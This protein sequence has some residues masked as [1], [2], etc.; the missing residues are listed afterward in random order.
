M[1]KGIHPSIRFDSIQFNSIQFNSIQFN[2]IQF[3]SSFRYK[4][5]KH[6][7]G[8]KLKRK[9]GA[10]APIFTSSSCLEL[11]SSNPQKP[12]DSLS[13]FD[14]A[15]TRVVEITKP[16][17]QWRLVTKPLQREILMSWISNPFLPSTNLSV[18]V[19]LCRFI[20]SNDVPKA[21][22]LFPDFDGSLLY[23]CG[24]LFW[25]KSFSLSTV[26]PD[27]WLAN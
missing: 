14:T 16:W 27:E 2:S 4:R 9:R 1:C 24:V 25:N 8:T 22:G 12:L 7:W 23:V 13:Q 20:R 15:P 11:F 21:V 19:P 10:G 5:N 6:W 3:N 17:N 26:P 18:S